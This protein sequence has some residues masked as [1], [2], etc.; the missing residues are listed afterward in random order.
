MR[1]RPLWSAAQIEL[2]SL[3]VL[4][5][6]LATVQLRPLAALIGPLHG[7]ACL[8]VVI[9]AW[10]HESADSTAKAAA[11]IPGIGGL[12]AHRRIDRTRNPALRGRGLP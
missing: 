11:V 6:N 4:L 5:T 2:V 12:L 8:F 3:I 1:P 10:R 9:T 7:C